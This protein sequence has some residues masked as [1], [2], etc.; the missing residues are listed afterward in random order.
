[1]ENYQEKVSEE[2]EYFCKEVPENKI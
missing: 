2:V 1:V